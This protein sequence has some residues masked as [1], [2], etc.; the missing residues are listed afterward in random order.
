MWTASFIME[1]YAKVMGVKFPK[2]TLDR[3]V[4]ILSSVIEQ[5]RSQLFHVI[6]VNPEITMACQRVGIFLKGSLAMF[7]SRVVHRFFLFF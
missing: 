7:K 3:T 1:N 2:I 5:K 6:T 4:E